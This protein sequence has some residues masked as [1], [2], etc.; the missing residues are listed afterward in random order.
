VRLNARRDGLI[1]DAPLPDRDEAVVAKGPVEGVIQ[2][3]ARDEEGSVLR[4]P[5]RVR[6][7]RPAA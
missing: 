1:F 7:W 6:W 3:S 2:V 4:M 5:H